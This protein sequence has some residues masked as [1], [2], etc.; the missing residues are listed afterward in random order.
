M[1]AFTTVILS[2]FAAVSAPN[3]ELLDF[4]AKWCGP[5]QQMAP[6]VDRLHRQ[7]YP[8]RKVDLDENRELAR[9]YGIQSIPAFVLVVNGRVVE[10]AT[11]LQS[12]SRLLQM[13]GRIP[14]PPTVPEFDAT[15][16]SP[17]PLL[18]ENRVAASR[19]VVTMVSNPTASA[20]KA[21]VR[22]VTS[23]SKPPVAPTR[24]FL[25]LNL[26]GGGSKSEAPGKKAIPSVVRANLEDQPLMEGDILT[27]DPLTASVRLRISDKEGVNLGS[28]TIIES[29]VG[30][31][32]ILTCGHI[33]RNLQPDS[34]IEADVFQNGQIETFVGKAVKHELEADVG[35]ISIP[36]DN[37]L[38]FAGIADTLHPPTKGAAVQSVGCGQGNKPTLQKHL[39]TQI[40]RYAG[41]ENI[42]C[43]GVPVQGR[44]GGGLFNTNGQL[45]GI[46]MAAD[47]KERRGLYVGLGAIQGFLK[48]CGLLRVLPQADRELESPELETDSESLLVH[49]DAEPSPVRGLAA[50]QAAMDRSNSDDIVCLV[51]S[52]RTSQAGQ[53]VVV[54][55]AKPAAKTKK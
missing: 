43:T 4:T 51:R 25:G 6:I 41:P 7:G 28:G 46:C 16:K 11:G 18:V 50:L 39:I 3:G 38:P 2:A 26:L 9:Q 10:Q 49:S 12:E 32:L 23:Q 31:T 17:S 21:P 44:S 45:V 53:R 19:D 42:E 14:K 36:T 40:N 52:A 15:T 34:V 30:Q 20:S 22:L 29:K 48:Q 8:V 5:C 35:L 1:H 37:P 54:L 47:T 33:F 13:L 24:G 27:Q 55:S